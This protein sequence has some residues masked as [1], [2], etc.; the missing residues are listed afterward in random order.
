MKKVIALMA[1]ASLFGVLALASPASADGPTVTL[2][3]ASVDEPGTHTIT[4][5][6]AGWAGNPVILACAGYG[7]VLP[8]PNQE[9]QENVLANCDIATMKAAALDG[10]SFEE[11]MTV[12]V[13]AEGLVVLAGDQASG[14]SGVALVSVGEP[15][16]GSDTGSTPVGGADTGF[17]RIGP[18]PAAGT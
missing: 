13:P 7:G 10:D 1:L 5:T 15:A 14:S 8:D 9:T 3:P 4:V 6:G 18:E 12:A 11:T 16:E 2:D 17:G